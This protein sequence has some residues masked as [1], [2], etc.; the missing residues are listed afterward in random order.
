MSRTA[1]ELMLEATL[2]HQRLMDEGKDPAEVGFRV[3]QEELRLLRAL[4]PVD[5]PLLNA[6]RDRL[7]GFRLEV[8]G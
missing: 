1:D 8:M 5:H 3:S 2:L 7:C 6:Q 4:P